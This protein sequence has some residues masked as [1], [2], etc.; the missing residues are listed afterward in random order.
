MK[1]P[2][3]GGSEIVKNGSLG[4]GKPKYKCKSCGRQFVENPQKGPISEET[5]ELIDKLLLERLSLAA[6]ARV[7]G[8]SEQ[9]LQTYVNKKYDNIPKK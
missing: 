8:V 6:I 1:C 9:W 7:T 5:K 4:N 3:C 2:D